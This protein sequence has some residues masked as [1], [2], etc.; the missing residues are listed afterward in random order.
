MAGRHTRVNILVEGQTEESFVREI[1]VPH[2]RNFQVYLIPRIIE[3]KKGC[4]GGVVSY[5]K[6]V[7]QVTQW[8]QDDATAQVTTLFDVYGLPDDF[9]SFSSWRS[10]QPSTPQVQALEK[11]L[12]D[13]INQSNFIP[14]LQL[15]EYEAL[16]FSDLD[17]FA[18]ANVD[19]WV[20]N[21]WKAQLAHFESPEEVNNSKLTAPS[22]RLIKTWSTYKH[23]KPH[24]G[25]LIALEIGLPKMREKCPRFNQWLIQLEAL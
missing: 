19:Q 9:P 16:L 20:I 8:C 14:Y 23:A 4:K 24:F 12:S 7:H 2:L 1:L 3:T 11:A 25:V 17:K 5:A 13:D 21:D 18:Y 15:H 10:N 6:I 22:K